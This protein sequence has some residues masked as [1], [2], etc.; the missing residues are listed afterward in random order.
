MIF[1]MKRPLLVVLLFNVVRE[2]KNQT[3]IKLSLI[4]QFNCFLPKQMN[5]ST[6]FDKCTS[7]PP[8]YVLI[9]FVFYQ[10]LVDHPK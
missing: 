7:G 6:C 10:S 8:W 9:Y 5:K 3:M 2:W 1:F 4:K